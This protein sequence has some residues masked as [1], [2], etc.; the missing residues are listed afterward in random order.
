[1][2]TGLTPELIGQL[3][4]NTVE[5]EKSDIYKQI[6][7]PRDQVLAR[8]Q[9]LFLMD[10][11]P[12]IG[13][14]EF[15]SFLLCENN[16]HWSGLHRQGTR[17]CLDMM[18]LRR[19]LS[20]LLAEHRPLAERLDGAV[21]D[22]SGMG[23][24]I[25]T[26]ILLIAHPDKYGVW[27]SRSEAQ[28]RQLGVWPAFERGKSIGA[29][30]AKV[31]QVLLQIRD[32]LETDL[33]ALDALWWFLDQTSEVASGEGTGEILELAGQTESDVLGANQHFGLQRHL[34]Q[35]LRDNWNG[36]ELF[37]EDRE[38][39]REPGD[40]EAGYEYPCDV[41]RIDLLVKHK[42]EARWLVI[43]LKRGQSTDQTIGQLSRY[44]G[45]VKQHLASKDETVQ[46]M[47][48]SRDVDRALQYALHA[49]P[50]IDVQLY[51]VEF[52]LR[53]APA[54]AAPAAWSVAEVG[55]RNLGQLLVPQRAEGELGACLRLAVHGLSSSSGSIAARRE[56]ARL[57]VPDRLGRVPGAPVS[58]AGQ[59]GPTAGGSAAAKR[60]R[61]WRG[62]GFRA[63]GKSRSSRRG[64]SSSWSGCGA[65]TSPRWPSAPSFPST[66]PWR[67]RSTGE[68][69][70]SRGRGAAWS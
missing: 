39:Y 53:P 63:R 61:R 43:E 27:N 68:T 21:N 10:H 32:A 62:T 65:S 52:R 51:E 6:V 37:K 58:F 35:F 34:H 4:A 45:W 31:N 54:L 12:A 23:K 22:V 67:R 48:I 46:G 40:E 57:P 55:P 50:N 69:P 26:A 2:T 59:R 11:I 41:G 29:R 56:T 3:R 49:V 47:I 36:I 13:A 20:T 60:R 42:R 18:K 14:E 28:M 64:R 17:M 38:I 25:A 8:F 9:P 30:Y 15:K 44:I 7:E 16:C 70:G 19:G 24:N 33:W 1:M 5:F 66:R